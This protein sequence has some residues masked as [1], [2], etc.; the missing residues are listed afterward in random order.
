MSNMSIS[1]TKFAHSCILA[2]TKERTA[3]FDPGIFSWKSGIDFEALPVVDRLVITHEHQDHF[4]MPFVKFL[5]RKFPDMHI[6]ADQTILNLIEKAN[7]KA[8]LRT[9]SDC[10]RPFKANHEVTPWTQEVKNKGFHFMDVLT[11]PGDSHSFDETKDILALP[12]TAPWG[13]LTNAVKLAVELKPR[14]V[15]PIHDWHLNSEAKKWYYNTC[16]STLNSKG[17]K[18]LDLIDGVKVDL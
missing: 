12:I 4:Y 18:F 7:I 8:R 6:V 10:L 17:I 11:H 3:L 1:V 5:V 16:Q 15:L 14:V 2:E 13:S 9:S